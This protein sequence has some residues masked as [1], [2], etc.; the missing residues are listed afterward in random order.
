MTDEKNFEFNLE[1]LGKDN[2]NELD[3]DDCAILDSYDETLESLDKAVEY[4]LKLYPELK[5]TKEHEDRSTEC[6][7]RVFA[8]EDSK[9]FKD[10][11]E[12]RNDKVGMAYCVINEFILENEGTAMERKLYCNDGDW[13]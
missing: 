3:V 9:L 4:A 6:R 8:G 5:A 13:S 7:T 12:L 2:D 11:E 10:A 1:I